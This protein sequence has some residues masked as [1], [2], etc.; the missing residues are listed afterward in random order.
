[1]TVNEFRAW[2]EGFE[3]SIQASPNKKQW[4]R[5]KQRLDQVD[6]EEKII[7]DYWPYPRPWWPQW[8]TYTI[9]NNGGDY[10]NDTNFQTTTISWS[11]QEGN[12][13]GTVDCNYINDVAYETGKL[14]S[15]NLTN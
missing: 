15:Q 3:E 14:E 6:S 8:Y 11:A 2:L 12:T 9:S 13:G 10:S 1:M 4:G 5:I 7:Y